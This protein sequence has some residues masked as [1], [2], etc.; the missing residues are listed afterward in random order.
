MMIVRCMFE[1]IRSGVCECVDRNWRLALLIILVA[2][3]GCSAVAPEASH[4]AIFYVS[5]AG[6]DDWSGT[7]SEPDGQGTDGPF[8]TVQRARDAVRDLKKRKSADIVVLIR[9]G[10]YQLEKTVVFGLEDSGVGDSTVT[11]AAYPG[12]TPVFSAGREIKGFVKGRQVAC[13]FEKAIIY[14]GQQSSG[15]VHGEISK[16]LQVGDGGDVFIV[17]MFTDGFLCIFN[18]VLPPSWSSGPWL[19]YLVHRPNG[20]PRK[21]QRTFIGIFSDYRSR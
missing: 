14:R 20:G 3:S 16:H 10:T 13:F 17:S 11:Y 7:L 12:E 19:C 5:P 1:G 18:M 4:K 2:G 8:A 9:E 15:M 6:C 21:N